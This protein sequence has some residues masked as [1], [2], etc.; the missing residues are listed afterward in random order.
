AYVAGQAFSSHFPAGPASYKATLSGGSDAFLV[1]GVSIL[2]TLPS[3]GG[4]IP[5][6][7][8]AA[9]AAYCCLAVAAFAKAGAMPLHSWIPD[10][11]EYAPVP[12]TALLPASLDKLLGIY[13]LA[14][15]H[16]TLFAVGDRVQLLCAIVGATTIVAAVMMAMVQH[17]LKRLLG[18]H[19][20]SQVGYMVL[21]IATGTPVG[22]AGA[23][24][25]MLNNCIYKTCLVLGAG[26]V[27]ERGGTAELDNLGGLA[28]AMPMTFAAMLVSSLA[29]SGIPPLNGFA[30]KWMIYQGIIQMNASGGRLWV[31]WLV[32]A[33]FGSVL[34]LAS[35]IKI[36]NAV[37][38]GPPS[39][40]IAQRIAGVR[41]VGALMWAP[42]AALAGLCVV[43]GVRAASLAVGRFVA[44]AVGAPIGYI[45]LWDSTLATWLILLGIACGLLLYL[46]G[47]RGRVR[48]TDPFLG[49][50]AGDDRMSLSGVDFYLTIREMGVLGW[51]YARA[52][53][54]VFDLYDQ[55]RRVALG[56]ARLLS[57]MHDGALPV[58][59]GWCLAGLL[60]LLY[61]LM[62]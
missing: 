37:Y 52:E 61:L 21:G 19:A 50:E 7:H 36:L 46:A 60:M 40:A 31:V 34:T 41:E 14:R 18:Y 1:L 20:V 38:L 43:F 39:R 48:R 32:A 49:G 26:A 10:C 13:L 33:M 27:E 9:V 17:N 30:S 42:M 62:R 11:A 8:G 23:I 44:P 58:Y 51:V 47:R 28:S 6:S 5:L 53:G 25:H 55:G 12:V 35:F 16:L 56:V 24:F 22:I 4:P 59:L 54:R 2:L 57:R 15:M 3:V 29:I 45:G